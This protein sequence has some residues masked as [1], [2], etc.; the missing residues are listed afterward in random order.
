MGYGVSMRDAE[1]R[2]TG[3]QNQYL[4][5]INQFIDACHKWARF[6]STDQDYRN[7]KIELSRWAENTMTAEAYTKALAQLKESF[8]QVP[9]AQIAPYGNGDPSPSNQ[10]EFADGKA[11]AARFDAV[12]SRLNEIYERLPPP[13]AP[14]PQPPTQMP[15]NG[16]SASVRFRLGSSTPEQQSLREALAVTLRFTRN[17]ERPQIVLV[18]YADPSGSRAANA[19]L[20]LRRAAEVRDSLVLQ[21]TPI[22]AVRVLSGGATEQFGNNDSDNRVVRLEMRCAPK[23]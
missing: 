21:G 16:L 14:N 8:E 9:S 5:A 11:I 19:D 3:A 22:S 4:I 15:F 13:S 10:Q 18:G 1:F 2:N 20:G 12:D 17:C 23:G 6:E 7:A